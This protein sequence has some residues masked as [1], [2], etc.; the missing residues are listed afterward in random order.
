MWTYMMLNIL[1][2][3]SPS[4]CYTQ[5][6]L[7]RLWMYHQ[8]IVYQVQESFTSLLSLQ[9]SLSCPH[10]LD[11]Q[12]RD[13]SVWEALA[14]LYQYIDKVHAGNVVISSDTRTLEEDWER[15][16]LFT[17]VSLVYVKVTSTLIYVDTST[18]VYIKYFKIETPMSGTRYGNMF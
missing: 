18:C 5:T 7:R 6:W 3:D 15:S 8:P 13:S 1:A 9:V 4:V 10:L 12:V 11:G 14:I 16:L 2:Q 17:Y